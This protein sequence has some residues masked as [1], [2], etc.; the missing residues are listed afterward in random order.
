MIS[1]SP[2]GKAHRGS[3]LDP[4]LSP[5]N[6]VCV[7]RVSRFGLCAAVVAAAAF[8][9]LGT[10]HSHAGVTASEPTIQDRPTLAVVGA[11][12]S[13]GVGAGSPQ[14]GWPVL[15]AQQL[16]WRSTV[17]ADPGAGYVALGSHKQGPMERLLTK[18]QLATDHP[19]V[20]IV[21]SGY[22]DIGMPP[23]Q[24]AANVHKVIS[25]IRTLAPDAAVGVLTVFP[26]GQASPAAWATDK[27]IV[28]A[29]RDT[30]SKVY[31]FDPLTSHWVFPTVSDRLH[32]TAA[33]HRWIANRLASDF[34]HYGLAH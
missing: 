24:L 31:V 10:Q 12:I 19:T 7:K 8:V 20:V 1:I 9:G 34:R 30:Y 13:D 32:P 16:G 29:A 3:Q 22:N 26:K 28:A 11:S 27:I 33:G 5:D 17:S 2:R 21:Q 4:A 14:K 15:L 18:L 25:Q 23:A 6:T